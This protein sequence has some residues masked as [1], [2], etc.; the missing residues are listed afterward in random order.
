VFRIQS[1]NRTDE[2]QFS[3]PTSNVNLLYYDL[4]KNFSD[5][6]RSYDSARLCTIIQG[7]K[8][9]SINNSERF[10]YNH[11]QFVLLPPHSTVFMSMTE[12]TKAL[13]YEFND[14]IID[15]VYQKVSDIL[16]IDAVQEISYSAFRLETLTDRLCSLHRRT[17]QI[18]IEEDV[19]IDF[20]LGLTSQEIIYELIKIK[21]CHEII[22]HHQKHPIN[23]AIRIMNSSEGN[24]M[25][26]SEIAESVDMSLSLFSQKF[27]TITL[28]TP[29]D[30]IKKLRLRKSLEYLQKMSV[31]DTAYELGFENISHY[32]KIFKQEYGITPKQYQLTKPEILPLFASK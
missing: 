1:F 26:I 11:K 12:Y 9:V 7:S 19:N 21:G 30:Y 10:V 13:V 25:S 2:T 27:K 4:P 23:K 22:H 14:E 31:T 20:L 32:I 5:E 3:L 8:E 18:I 15:E 6:Y 24:R 16:R 29:R 17:Q 28:L